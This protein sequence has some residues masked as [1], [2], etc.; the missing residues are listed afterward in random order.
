MDSTIGVTMQF[1]YVLVGRSMPILRAKE[2]YL[3]DSANKYLGEPWYD[4]CRQANI[5]VKKCP[6]PK[7]FYQLKNFKFDSEKMGVK[8]LPFGMITSK[9]VIFNNRNQDIL[10]CIIAEVD[11]MEK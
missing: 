5:P 11:N 7:G 9:S 10:A 1:D 2:N 4:A 3:C 8:S 6:I